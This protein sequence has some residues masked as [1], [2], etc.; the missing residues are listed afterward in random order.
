MTRPAPSHSACDCDLDSLRVAVWGFH[1]TDR[2]DMPWRETRDPYAVLVSEVMLQQTQ[3]SRVL[4][5]YG[6]FIEA[7]P[8]LDALAAAPLAAVLEQWRGLGYD[9]RALNLKRTAELVSA[10]YGGRLPSDPAVLAGMPG[11]GPA[12][13]AAVATYAFGAFAPFIETNVRAVFLHHC[14][15]DA[16]RV[17]D[18][19][20]MPLV[21]AA[22]DRDDPR[23]WGY[24]LMDYGSELK[25]TMPNPSRRSTHHREQ[26]WFEGSR[27]Q[28]RAGILRDVLARPGGTAAEY[29]RSCGVEPATARELLGELEAEGFLAREGERYSVVG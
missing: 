1:R 6:G 17:P 22:W 23:E 28:K 16:D 26:S 8:S 5:K 25:R 27:R 3:V 11:I 14:F 2:R 10:S 13:A 29:A 21:E 24:A 18:R 12:T 15:P 19:E 4:G 9:R 20:L 7:F